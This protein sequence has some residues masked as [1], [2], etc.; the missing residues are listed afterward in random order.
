VADVRRR[1]ALPGPERDVPGRAS[2]LRQAR[3]RGPDRHL[4][5][6]RARHEVPPPDHGTGLL[7][8]ERDL[9]KRQRRTVAPLVHGGHARPWAPRSPRPRRRRWSAGAAPRNAA[10]PWTSGAP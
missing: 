9:W 3:P 4:S 10:S 5:P 1:G 6:Q 8:S 7:L 2:R